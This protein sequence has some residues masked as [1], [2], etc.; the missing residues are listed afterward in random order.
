MS[1]YT[2]LFSSIIHSS[3]WQLDRHVKLTWVTMLAM[4]DRDGIVEASVPGLASAAGVS[5]PEAEQALA[6]LRAPDPH[7]RTE[8]DEG[9]RVRKVEGGWLVINHDLY[10][11]RSSVEDYR[12]KNAARQ[13]R[14]RAARA[15]RSAATAESNATSNG[16]TLH[17]APCRAVS[18]QVTP[19][20]ATLL[21]SA[22]TN[23][24]RAPSAPVVGESLRFPEA[25]AANFNRRD[26]ERA[27]SAERGTD[28]RVPVAAFHVRQADETAAHIMAAAEKAG[29]DPHE[30]ARRAF[31][32]WLE[33]Q[34]SVDPMAWC[35]NW[36]A[37]LPPAPK[38]QRA[39]AIL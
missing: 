38:P 13:A 33:S 18:R 20:T 10:N 26:L 27:V 36:S 29:R 12:A 37:A 11:D 8:T 15:A 4:K 22:D 35:T 34:K 2:K 5:L 6:I 32:G 14:L 17:V 28:W 23:T 9:R 25:E 21:C 19:S 39:R 7:S 31:R 24:T 16:V 30:L 3:V 1:S